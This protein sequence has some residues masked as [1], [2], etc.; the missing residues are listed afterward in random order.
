MR[1]LHIAPLGVWAGLGGCWIVVVCALAILA[2]RRQYLEFAGLACGIGL[3]T[4][5]AL[6]V[7]DLTRSMTLRATGGAGRAARPVQIRG[8]RDGRADR[9]GYDAGL[10][11]AA[12]VVRAVRRRDLDAAVSHAVDPP[13]GLPAAWLTDLPFL[14]S[15]NRAWNFLLVSGIQVDSH[16]RS[17]SGRQVCRAD[18]AAQSRHYGGGGGGPGPGHRR[19]Y[20]D[21]LRGLCRASAAAAGAQRRQAG[22][23]GAGQREDPRQRRA[24][25]ILHV[26]QLEAARQLLRFDR[27]RRARHGDVLRAGEC[28]HPILPDHGELSADARRDSRD[29]EKFHRGR[30]PAGQ[31]AN[32]AGLPRLLARPPGCRPAC[33]GPRR[34]KWMARR[35][36]WSASCRR[37]STWMAVPPMSMHRWRAACRVASFCRST[38]TPA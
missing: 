20:G 38:S 35:S 11:A 7:E 3:V 9:A 22:D 26:R 37:A 13:A 16:D 23:H 30:R 2:A 4:V 19:Q 12:D 15:D 18:A 17:D 32:G 8:A 1:N 6:V 10:R 14:Q 28:G 36:P 27:R 29:G 31:A 5:S 33:A 24:A 21:F 34:S 25:R